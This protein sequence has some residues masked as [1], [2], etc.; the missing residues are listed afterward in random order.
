VGNMGA[1]KLD[2]RQITR[3]AGEGG[4]IS[5]H[6]DVETSESVAWQCTF[7]GNIFVGPVVLISA[8][9]NGQSC[10]VVIDDP[11]RFGEFATED[12]I[13]R[14][15]GAWRVEDWQTDDCGT[16]RQTG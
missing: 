7:R 12:W 15:Y 10:T 11:R 1:T 5:Y 3:V 6:V 9:D 2:I 8:A 4:H 16:L 14:F 13:R